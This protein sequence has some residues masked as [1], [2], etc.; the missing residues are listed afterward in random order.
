MNRTLLA[1]TLTTALCAPA[2]AQTPMTSPAKSRRRAA[3]GMPMGD[4]MQ[5]ISDEKMQ[6][7][8]QMHLKMGK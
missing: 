5:G 7:M 4:M 2:F 3:P 8:R 1:L 6:Q